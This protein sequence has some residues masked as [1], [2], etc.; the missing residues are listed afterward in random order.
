M[1]TATRRLFSALSFVAVL[2][3]AGN[4]ASIASGANLGRFRTYTFNPAC[5]WD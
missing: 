5:V 3:K 4:A 1:I 2:K